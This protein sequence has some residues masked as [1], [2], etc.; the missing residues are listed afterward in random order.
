MLGK[1]GSQNLLIE[2]FNAQAEVVQI[3]AFVSRS[4]ATCR[5]KLAIDW[6]QVDERVAGT[7][8]H[9]A[10]IISPPFYVA[11]QNIAIK[12]QHRFEIDDPQNDMVDL[13]DGNRALA[14]GHRNSLQNGRPA[15]IH[16]R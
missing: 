13:A 5:S 8:L 12:G 14:C 1:V 15:F 7:K 2:M 9:Q 4:G 16:E 3:P 6:N 11:P 10:Q